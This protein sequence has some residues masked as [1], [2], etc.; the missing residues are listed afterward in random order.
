MTR[1]SRL[2]FEKAFDSSFRRTTMGNASLA[3]YPQK[4]I[5]QLREGSEIADL[6]KARADNRATM[7]RR[8][9]S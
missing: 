8:T 9:R 2:L 4:Q 1:E 3:R 6:D 5:D 7:R